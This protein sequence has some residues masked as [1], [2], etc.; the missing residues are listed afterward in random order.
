M[1]AKNLGRTILLALLP[2]ILTTGAAFASESEEVGVV[3]TVVAIDTDNFTIEIEV[4]VDSGLELYVVQVGQNFDFETIGIGDEIE[5]KGTLNEDGTLVLM[6]EL[7]I[8]ERA[9]DKVKFQDGELDSYYCTSDQIH[10]VAAKIAET[11]EEDYSVIEGYLCGEPSTPLGQIMLALQTAALQDGVDF[12]FYLDGFENSNWGQ[13]WQELELDIKGK[14][15]HGTPPGQIQDKQGA[16]DSEEPDANGK[17]NKDSDGLL[18]CED[19]GLFCEAYE[20]FQS[21]SQKGKK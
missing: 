10:P 14:P 17:K 11:Y 8:Q 21:Q 18:E 2:A 6:T 9:Q 20:W 19:G 4:E 12:T 15:D 16:G 7:K 5:V 3:G 13:I 1:K